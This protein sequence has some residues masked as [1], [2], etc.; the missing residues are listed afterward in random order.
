MPPAYIL[1]DML[2]SDMEQYRQYMAAA[3]AAVVAVGGEYLVRGG[4]LETLK[5]SGDR[6]GSPCCDFRTMPRLKPFAM[7]RCIGPRVPNARAQPNFLTWCSST[8]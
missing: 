7:A 3:P 1:V 8:A 5:D 2:I 4:R 6:A